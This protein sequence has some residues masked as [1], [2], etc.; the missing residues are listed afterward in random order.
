MKQLLLAAL[1]L[2]LAGSQAQAQL[3]NRLVSKSSTQVL[4]NG[5]SSAPALDFLGDHI[6]FESSATNL[7]AGDTNGVRDV[8]VREYST[9]TTTR[10]SEGPGGVEANARCI[11][12]DISGDGQFVAFTSAA[13]NLTPMANGFEQVYVRDLAA[14]TLELISIDLDGLPGT[15]PSGEATLSND[16]RWVLFTS[17]AA[18]VAPETEGLLGNHLYLRDRVA[19][20]TTWVDV[21]YHGGLPA[22]GNSYWGEIA[23]EGSFATFTSTVPD[24]VPGDT[25]GY[26]DVFRVDL[27]S[28]AIEAVSVTL[29]GTMRPS[30]SSAI[31]GNGRYV[32]FYSIWDD[33]DPNLTG[34]PGG[35]IYFRDMD[36]GMTDLVRRGGTQFSNGAPVLW[37]RISDDGRYIAY[38]FAP[39]VG[40]SVLPDQANNSD[41]WLHDTWLNPNYGNG[42]EAE[43][44]SLGMNGNPANGSSTR[45]GF[46][47]NGLVLGYV[48]GATNLIPL[49]DNGVDDVYVDFRAYPTPMKYCGQ[50]TSGGCTSLITYTG[51]PSATAGDFEVRATNLPSQKLGMIIW[52]HDSAIAPWHGSATVT[53]RCVLSPFVRTGVQ[54]TGSPG[55]PCKGRVVLDFAA[56][57]AQHPAKAPAI[58][59]TV[60]MQGWFRPGMGTTGFSQ[61]LAFQ[62]AP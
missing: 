10:A 58:G 62:W 43:I 31:S 32:A 37:P 19:G 51:E 27:Q 20:T 57:A 12:P 11:D 2:T 9:G 34:G 49:D 55:M 53:P 56:W 23:A 54:N 28:G 39:D 35:N 44:A 52:S 36:L 26:F 8:F 61:A 25:N 21:P 60:Y 4:G 16:G 48:S 13:T 33:L 30:R 5:P 24:L 17:A 41:V 22:P 47:G 14:G 38:V 29:S 6:V 59:S 45:P 42:F 15:A 7:V 40:G 1:F 3:G 18:R 46:S 50:T